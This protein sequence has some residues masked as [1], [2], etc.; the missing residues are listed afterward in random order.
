M[1]GRARPWL[2]V[3]NMLR[4]RFQG[5]IIDWTK[6]MRSSAVSFV[7]RHYPI[8]PMR[9]QGGWTHRTSLKP[10]VDAQN[11]SPE[12]EICRVGSDFCAMLL[13]LRGEVWFLR[14][15]RSERGSRLA[16]KSAFAGWREEFF[17]H[18]PHYHHYRSP[19]RNPDLLM[20][21]SLAPALQTRSCQMSRFLNDGLD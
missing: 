19:V 2:Q 18:A 3:Y 15:S 16:S 6:Y 17:S 5:C 21:S 1:R 10:V 20:A 9:L 11:Q 8:P 7:F 4:D 13:A 12:S 14:F